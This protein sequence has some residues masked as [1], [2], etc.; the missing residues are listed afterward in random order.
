MLFKVR[1]HFVW[2]LT[3]FFLLTLVFIS[4]AFSQSTAQASETGTKAMAASETMTDRISGADRYQTAV[5]VSQKGWKTSDYAVLA[6]GDNFADALCAGPLAQKYGG[7]IL[8]TGTNQL[9]ADTLAELQRLGVKHLFIAGGVGAVSQSVEDALKTA[10]I[11]TIERIY[12][13][14]RYETSVKLAQKIGNTGKVVLATGSDFPDA[15]SISGIAA[16]LGMPILLTAKNTVPASVNSY[17]QTNT[18]TQTY[19]VGGI[20][21]IS[22][23]VANSVPG[24]SRLAGSDRYATNVAVMQNFASELDFDNIYVAIGTN[25]ADALTGAVLASK[26]SS[27]LVLTAKSLPAGT[28]N[29]L[30]TKPKL[31]SKVFGLGGSSVVSSAV[32]SAVLT[33]IV[34][35]EEQIPVPA[36]VPVSAIPLTAK[37]LVDG[38]EKSLEAYTINGKEYFKLGDLSL[39]L[40]GTRKG[41]SAAMYT[42]GNFTVIGTGDN[43]TSGIT[44][45]GSLVKGDGTTK[46][47]NPITPKVYYNEHE[48]RFLTVYDINGN[49][50]YQLDE[51]MALIRCGVIRDKKAN[52]INLATDK[53]YE[54]AFLPIPQ[55]NAGYQKLQQELYDA[56]LKF[57]AGNRENAVFVNGRV[58]VPDNATLYVPSGVT[59][60]THSG[61][62]IFLGNNATYHNRGRWIVEYPDRVLFPVSLQTKNAIY[63]EEDPFASYGRMNIYQRLRGLTTGVRVRLDGNGWAWNETDIPFEAASVSYGPSQ[64]GVGEIILNFTRNTTDIKQDLKVVLYEKGGATHTIMHRNVRKNVDLMPELANIVGKNI[65]KNTTITKIDVYNYYI[66][67]H[68]DPA[69]EVVLKP[70]SIPVNWNIVTS[71]NAPTID[72]LAEFKGNN[73]IEHVLNFYGLENNTY[74]AKYKYAAQSNDVEIT[75]YGLISPK[76]KYAIRH[77]GFGDEMISELIVGDRS[78][79]ALLKGQ[80]G[81]AQNSYVFTVSPISQDIM[82]A[83]DFDYPAEASLTTE[84]NKTYLNFKMVNPQGSPSIYNPRYL[85]IRAQIK[86]A[87]GANPKVLFKGE[88]R[89]DKFDIT[90][91]LSSQIDKLYIHGYL[92]NTPSA[93]YVEITLGSNV[94]AVESVKL[95]A[96]TLV[97]ISKNPLPAQGTGIMTSNVAFKNGTGYSVAKIQISP[98]GKN[99]WTDLL[100]AL[101]EANISKQLGTGQSR[102]LPMTF[103]KGTLWDIKGTYSDLID[104]DEDMNDVNRAFVITG[105]D[106]S[107]ISSAPGASIELRNQI[108]ARETVAIVTNNIVV[109]APKPGDFGTDTIDVVLVAGDKV[110]TFNVSDFSLV[111]NDGTTN[112]Y[113]HSDIQI[114]GLSQTTAGNATLTIARDLIPQVNLHKYFNQLNIYYKDY[115]V[116][117]ITFNL[118]N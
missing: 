14:D 21:V 111:L 34:P 17:F 81:A 104:W 51:L 5:A 41:F 28:A 75:N 43:T 96:D 53:G 39:A 95:G 86:G 56:Y 79:V 22:D 116:G 77:I 64:H 4:P 109:S 85:M 92:G 80:K 29:H 58:T 27:P 70:I 40:K 72:K 10:G 68:D 102:V 61:N 107:G 66:G 87:A 33:G 11:A 94:S 42:A 19:V 23:S 93:K 83:A 15:L 115:K 62:R 35:A 98:T 114:V 25:F 105:V 26:S 20:G 71:G 6:R 73:D 69:N 82:Y 89:G 2:S 16:K 117:T 101:G 76:N 44:M 103:N 100:S 24:S 50:Y 59:I 78:N 1:K 88:V 32:L 67:P 3:L 54:P 46:K 60:E 55:G 65:G 48:I 18:I 74:I 63:V 9:N 113:P 31:P 37:V 45:T 118:W 47:A 52:T 112:K 8:L 91:L 57:P 38:V 7:P 110:K 12:G 97:N 30:K 36:G 99:S 13:A 49:A 106:F 84:N 90:Q 108:F